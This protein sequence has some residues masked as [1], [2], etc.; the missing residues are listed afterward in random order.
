MNNLHN[1]LFFIIDS[2]LTPIQ[3]EGLQMG[4]LRLGVDCPYFVHTTKS[5]VTQCRVLEIILQ[6]SIIL[7]F[8][9]E[10]KKKKKKLDWVCSHS[11]GGV[12]CVKL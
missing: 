11:S 3:S 4:G 5:E 10:K 7:E 1:F 9:F 6:L 8:F 12:N 2:N